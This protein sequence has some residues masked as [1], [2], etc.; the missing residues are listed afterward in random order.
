MENELLLARLP[1]IPNL[2][3][4]FY[5]IGYFSENGD[6]LFSVITPQ[7][8]RTFPLRRIPP[9]KWKKNEYPSED[10]EIIG[11]IQNP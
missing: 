4:D 5:G 2:D 6:F 11:K 9:E 1:K 8:M 10:G 7:M 3:K